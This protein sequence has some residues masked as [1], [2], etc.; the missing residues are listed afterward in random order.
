MMPT[1]AHEPLIYLASPYSH[2]DAAVRQS[3]YE[4]VC[5]AAGSMIA[6]GLDVYSPIAHSHG[7]A[8]HSEHANTSWQDWERLDLA[9]LCRSDALVVLM[10]DGWSVSVGVR[11]E[12][13]FA[14]E[15][16]RIPVVYGAA[17][18]MESHLFA[19]LL[20]EDALRARRSRA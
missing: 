20:R 9:M 3:R 15:S 7:I 17:Q 12:L 14:H 13:Q 19:Q 2:D 4:A 6:R 8:E 16:M 11:A 18:L 1:P 5:R 10:L